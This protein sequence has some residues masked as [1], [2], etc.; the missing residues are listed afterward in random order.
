M[1]QET[2]I[3]KGFEILQQEKLWNETLI[4]VFGTN[5]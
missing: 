4:D 1:I 5:H 2:H 3:K